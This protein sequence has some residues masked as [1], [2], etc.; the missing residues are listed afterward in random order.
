MLARTVRR[1][2]RAE[3]TDETVVATTLAEADSRIVT[4]CE[5]LGAPCFRGS[6]EDVLDR[7][8]GTAEEYN[9]EAVVRVTSDC[10]FIDPGI[11]DRV[12]RIFLEKRPDYAGNV[13]VRTYPR[14]LDTEIV[15]MDALERTWEEASEPHQRA[16]VT[17]YIYAADSGFSL[18]AVTNETDQSRY[19]WTVDTQQDLEMARALYSRLGNRDDFQWEEALQVVKNNP[20]LTEMNRRVRQKSLHEG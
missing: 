12:G 18:L 19:R 1:A 14:G 8:Y 6:E 3:L 10:P 4:E 7:Y 17:N 15:T 11:I 16:N 20:E 13:H 2:A 5:H 9:A